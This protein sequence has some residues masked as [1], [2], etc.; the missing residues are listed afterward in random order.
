MRDFLAYGLLLAFSVVLLWF[1]SQL[2]TQDY[3]YGAEDNI[4][5]RSVETVVLAVAF[6]LS[7]ERIVSLFRRYIKGA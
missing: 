7:I 5:I 3:Y 2:W 6:I 4:A 1:F